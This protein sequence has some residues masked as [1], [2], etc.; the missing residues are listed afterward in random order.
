MKVHACP[1]VFRHLLS[2]ETWFDSSTTTYG[3]PIRMTTALGVSFHLHIAFTFY[4]LKA[5]LTSA[6]VILTR[7]HFAHRD[8]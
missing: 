4:S 3:S 7:V 2:T 8:P 6:Y 5:A 1:K